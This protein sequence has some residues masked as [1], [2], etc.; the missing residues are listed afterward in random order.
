MSVCPTIRS[1]TLIGIL[2][3]T[4]TVVLCLWI[5]FTHPA[6]GDTAWFL[7]MAQQGLRGATLYR[8]L[9]DVNPPAIV[10]FGMPVVWVADLVDLP[11]TRLFS[12]VVVV[13]LLVSSVW[14]A[15]M[16]RRLC[17]RPAG[18]LAALSLAAVLLFSVANLTQRD[19]LVLLGLWPWVMTTALRTSGVKLS[20][21]EQIAAG[22]AAAIAIAIKPPYLLVPV[23]LSLL[24]SQ[25]RPWRDPA[26]QALAS[27]GVADVLAVLIWAPGYVPTVRVLAAD[28]YRYHQLGIVG[29]LL[30]SIGVVVLA[31]LA[32]LLGAAVRLRSRAVWTAWLASVV[33]LAAMLTQGKG[34]P[35]QAVPACIG[36]ALTAILAL[37]LSTSG[38]PRAWSIGALMILVFSPLGLPVL[39][40]LV[41]PADYELRQAALRRVIERE[42]PT[43]TVLIVS[44]A[45]F[46]IWPLILDLGRPWP[47]AI[48]S[49]WLGPT[50]EAWP[51]FVGQV[52]RAV[53]GRPVLI[54]ARRGTAGS[55]LAARPGGQLGWM[56]A[57]PILGPALATYDTLPD[58]GPYAVLRRPR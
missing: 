21:A 48:P 55:G 40:V 17:R 44:P 54:F 41:H 39:R 49:A 29:Q 47:L 33:M 20:T 4:V 43:G 12:A 38:L 51:W 18:V 7:Y 9:V 25:P 35:Y 8:D 3:T 42:A 50:A 46:D 11:V 13:L 2:V 32:L 14:W 6:N 31:A 16:Y 53:Q 34:F 22:L 52:R 19:T 1:R 57:D 37:G 28:Y 10:W 23:T 5:E 30:R 27:V 58:A 24:P 15:S 56:R 45:M 26:W 36:A